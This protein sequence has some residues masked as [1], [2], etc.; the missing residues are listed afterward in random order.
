MTGKGHINI[1]PSRCPGHCAEHFSML[2]AY[3]TIL[4]SSLI[5]QSCS[6]WR[7]ARSSYMLQY[8]ELPYP[9][10]AF[11]SGNWESF[12]KR[13]EQPVGFYYDML[14]WCHYG[15]HI[16]DRQFSPHQPETN[17]KH[18]LQHRSLC[19]YHGEES[20]ACSLKMNFNKVLK[21]T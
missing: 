20:R 12:L 18:F 19:Q 8:S 15:V 21:I 16:S 9:P 11:T 7:R 14:V 5:S 3:N 1:N 10:P 4:M 6:G 13:S 17:S 2:T